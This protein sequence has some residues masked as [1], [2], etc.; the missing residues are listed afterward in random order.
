MLT[1]QYFFTITALFEDVWVT[2]ESTILNSPSLHGSFANDS[3]RPNFVILCCLYIQWGLKVTT[4]K[5]W[6][7]RHSIADLQHVCNAIK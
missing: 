2:P 6:G 1:D 3:V 4:M 7:Q 5:I